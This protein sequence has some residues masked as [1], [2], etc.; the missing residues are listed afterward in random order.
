MKKAIEAADI[1]PELIEKIGLDGTSCT[2][3]YLDENGQPM[4]DAL[5]WMD[6]RASKEAD[7]IAACG[8][9]ALKAG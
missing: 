5:M 2:V 7:E 8:D 1:N 9:P 6:I 4:R 3:V